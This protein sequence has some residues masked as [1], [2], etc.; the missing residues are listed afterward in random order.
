MHHLNVFGDCQVNASCECVGWS[1]WLNVSVDVSDSSMFNSVKVGYLY[2]YT[3]N[4]ALLV[5]LIWQGELEMSSQFIIWIEWDQT[6]ITFMD[7][8]ILWVHCIEIWILCWLWIL[9]TYWTSGAVTYDFY[10]RLYGIT[11][12]YLSEHDNLVYVS[13]I[14]CLM[15]LKSHHTHAWS[16]L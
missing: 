5:S 16:F 4:L 7:L 12:V 2:S 14:T 9:F 15:C 3:G 10:L 8:I 1:H 11:W 13:C 6:Y